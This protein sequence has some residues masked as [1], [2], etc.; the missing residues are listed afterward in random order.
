MNQTDTLCINTIRMLA[1]DAIEQAKSGHPGLPLGAAPMA[2]VLWTRH[3][4]F[5][6]AN[7]R[8]PN[9][10]RFV[11]SG[12]HGSMLLYALLHLSGYE[13]SL[14]EI[15][16]FRQWDSL[17]PGHP[18]HGHNGVEVT[19]GP[20]GQGIS[21][22]V[23]LAIG[24]AHLAARFN[25][26]GFPLVD[27]YTYVLA[28]DGD[29]MEGVANEACA[30]AGHLGLGKLIV[31]HDD[32][33]V[34][35]AGTTD[36]TFTENL[37]Q[38]YGAYGW[39]VQAVEDGNDLA[40]IDEAIEAAKKETG[41][42]SLI[43][44]RTVIGYGAPHKQG[45]YEAHGAPLGPQEA[46]E[47]RKNLGWPPEPPFHVPDEALKVFRW[48]QSRGR[49]LEGRWTGLLE[50]YEKAFPELADEFK[51]RKADLLPEGWDSGL[52]AYPAGKSIATRKA[53]EEILQVLGRNIPEL[54]GG[55]ADLNN[56]VFAW[57]KGMGD[58]QRPGEKP[59]G[60]QGAVGGEWGYGGRNIHFGVREHA[61]GAIANGLAAYGGI[62]PFTGTFLVFSDYMRP[63]IRLAALSHLKVLFIFSHDSIGVGEDGPTHQPIEH[64]MALR[65]VPNLTVLRPADAN[66]T[67]A[68]W[69]VALGRRN[70]T[71]FVFSRQN[72]PVL[73]ASKYP[74]AEGVARGAY[75]LVDGGDSPDIVLIATGSEVALALRAADELAV[76]RVRA[77]VVS[78]PSWEL[79]GEQPRGYRDAVIPP[80]VKKRLAIE[81]GATLGWWKWVGDEGD[82][83]GI[84]RFGASAPGDVLMEKF[85]FTVENVVARALKLLGRD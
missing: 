21:N 6:P 44:V 38:H 62:L 78:M 79:F 34:S 5:N 60:V 29:L 33:R 41:R 51:R 49:Q 10:D 28:S 61:M 55:T 19:T 1:V 43:C 30:L 45:R 68:A 40:A 12:G 76:K 23:G 73:D 31:L 3:L 54:M 70:P 42:P 2:Y 58:F 64:L 59:A 74:V 7:P 26:E 46:E 50:R 16:K 65:A 9:R 39:H 4:R 22:A 80:A 72:L 8:W 47:T 36:L 56:S 11:L 25:R 15:K 13:L 63:P 85:G 53:S 77:R 84:D 32:N 48:A 20:L 82:V 24:E 37:A 57:L 75:V 52:A 17:T 18:E 14:A 83:I 81:A 35:L 69:K 71:V 27:H 67:L 66:E